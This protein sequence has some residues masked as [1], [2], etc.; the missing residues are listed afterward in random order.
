MIYMVCVGNFVEKWSILVVFDVPNARL[1]E[2]VAKNADLGYRQAGGHLY[3]FPLLQKCVWLGL[4][5]QYE[6]DSEVPK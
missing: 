5:W 3:I 6:Y 2:L 1:Q 4:L